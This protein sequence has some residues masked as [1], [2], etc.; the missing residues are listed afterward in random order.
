MT[1]KKILIVDDEEDLCEILQYNLGNEGYSTEIAH[2]AEEALKRLPGDFD[3]LL[4][5]VM[6]GQISGFRLADI[7]RREIKSS[8][9][10]IFLTAKDTEND[11]LT[12][13]SLGADDYIAKPFSVNE[14]TARV[15]A[16]LKRTH[17]D[18]LKNQGL[19]KFGEIELDTIR[20]RL[21]LSDEKTDLTRKEYEILKLLL[22]NPGKVFSREDILVKVWGM[23]VIVTE[24][25]VDVN[26]ARLR[27][28]LGSFS[29]NLK[30]KTGYGYFFEF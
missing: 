12:G 27:I 30:N 24:R 23:D 5:D 14:L 3:L 29:Q 4:L 20:K 22:E 15:K 28:K 21:I 10:I 17:K 19:L 18:K 25:T 11:I 2:S 7:L 1:G 9:P 16:V 6:M 8:V 13:F 26:I